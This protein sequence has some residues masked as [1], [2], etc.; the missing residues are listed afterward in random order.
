MWDKALLL[1]GR[2]GPAW[3]HGDLSPGNVLVSGGRLSAVIDFGG[4]GVGDPTGDQ[5]V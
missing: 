1:T 4:V 5:V 3:T 2:G